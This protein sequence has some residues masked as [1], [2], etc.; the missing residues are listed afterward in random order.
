M[1]RLPTQRLRLLRQSLVHFGERAT[2]DPLAEPRRDAIELGLVPG[3]VVRDHATVGGARLRDQ[4]DEQP[5][6]REAHEAHVTQHDPVETR[7]HHEAE[8]ARALGEDLRSDVH[9][10]L[11][12]GIREPARDRAHLVRRQD[13]AA[14]E[15]VDEEPQAALASAPARRSCDAA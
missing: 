13:L 15:L 10:A 11:G 7:R 9:R 5:I 12:V 8:L 14:L 6:A 1:P 4:H 2:G 3:A